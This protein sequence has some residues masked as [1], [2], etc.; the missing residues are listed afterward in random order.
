M[1]DE[2]TLKALNKAVEAFYKYLADEGL[3]GAYW[4]VEFTAYELDNGLNRW[5]RVTFEENLKI[6]GGK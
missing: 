2:N 1:F 5:R 3:D 6:E 4:D